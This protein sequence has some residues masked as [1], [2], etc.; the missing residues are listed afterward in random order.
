[1]WKVGANHL[2]FRVTACWTLSGGDAEMTGLEILS[3]IVWASAL[4]GSGLAVL[5]MAKWWTE[6]EEHV[7]PGPQHG[8][9]VANAV[10]AAR[11]KASRSAGASPQQR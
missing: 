7:S 3:L 9:E 6:V 4:G 11:R 8:D 2:S 1:M 5:V 10:S